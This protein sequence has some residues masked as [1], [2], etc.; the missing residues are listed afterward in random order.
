MVCMCLT[1]FWFPGFIK[2]S[3]ILNDS[4]V[5][6]RFHEI[7]SNPNPLF[8]MAAETPVKPPEQLTPASFLSLSLSLQ[9]TVD[10][11]LIKS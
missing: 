11:L 9:S 1:L 5:I 7:V 6:P 3:D 2:D 10:S 4:I 8:D